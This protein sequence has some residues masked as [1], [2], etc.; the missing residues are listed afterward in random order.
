M[1]LPND[2]WY[3]DDIIPKTTQERF[4]GYV[5]QSLFDWN[6]F[7]YILTAGVYGTVPYTAN[8]NELKVKPSDALIKLA[9]ANNGRE[10]LINNQTIYWLGMSIL[11]EYA[12]RN[13]VI[14]TDV[15]RMKVNNQTKSIW[16][17]WNENYCNDIHVDNEVPNNKTLVYY[18]NDA[19]GDTILFDKLFDGTTEH[20]DLN[21]LLRA[22]PVQ[23]RAVVFDTWRF[24]APSNPIYSPRRYILNINFTELAI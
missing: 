24:H 7:S 14:I 10:R 23:G 18:I 16:P 8:C 1:D 15:L 17:E 21:V 19:D 9:Y 5:S 13:N 20:Y 3:C 6:D 2:I 22:H 12:K 4:R 11:D